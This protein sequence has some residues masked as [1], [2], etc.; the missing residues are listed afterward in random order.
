MFQLHLVTLCDYLIKGNP[1]S[2]KLSFGKT[3]NS[4]PLFL[5]SANITTDIE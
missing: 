1:S 4:G 3:H 2:I 5:E